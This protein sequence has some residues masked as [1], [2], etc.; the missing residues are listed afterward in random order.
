MGHMTRD[1]VHTQDA[2]SDSLCIS[3]RMLV[4]SEGI[5]QSNSQ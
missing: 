5:W 1:V 4:P 2:I 3:G